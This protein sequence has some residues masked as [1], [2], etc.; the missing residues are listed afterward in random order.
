[1]SYEK[2][3]QRAEIQF[4]RELEG[5][6]PVESV[7]KTSADGFKVQKTVFCKNTILILLNYIT[8]VIYSHYNNDV[9]IERKSVSKYLHEI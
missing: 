9:T 7:F 8:H 5:Y 3:M 1:M 6:V 4:Q 2:I